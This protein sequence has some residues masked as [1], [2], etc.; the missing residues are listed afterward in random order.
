MKEE[1]LHVFSLVT[2]KGTS[3]K[4]ESIHV[5]SLVTSKPRTAIPLRAPRRRSEA[6]GRSGVSESR[7]LL[8]R[9]WSLGRLCGWSR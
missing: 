2:L 7:A 4:E 5:V 8:L 6:Q 3:M 9:R 1:S